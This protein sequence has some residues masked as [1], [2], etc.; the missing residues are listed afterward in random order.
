MLEQI[1]SFFKNQHEVILVDIDA[2]EVYKPA[3]DEPEEE[4]K[5]PQTS[6]LSI[7]R[8]LSVD[9]S[10]KQQE[11][12]ATAAAKQELPRYVEKDPRYVAPASEVTADSQKTIDQNLREVFNFYC[13]KFA[14]VR[15]DFSNKG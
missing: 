7:E 13:R 4:L 10:L 14:D 5:V 15:G 1:D 3:D 12:K 8:E 2:L 11:V 6:D 9:L